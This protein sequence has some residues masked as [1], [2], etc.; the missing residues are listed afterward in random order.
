MHYLI[1]QNVKSYDDLLCSSGHH[2]E[3]VHCQYVLL[4]YTVPEIYMFALDV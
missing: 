4:C 2:V 3:I 1:D